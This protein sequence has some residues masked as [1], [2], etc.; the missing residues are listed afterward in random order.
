M[1]GIFD[2]GVGGLTVLHAIRQNLPSADVIYFGDTKN[3][4]YGEKSREKLSD[5]TVA[6][7]Q[8][9]QRRGAHNIVS[10]C[11]SVSASLAVSLLDA[12]DLQPGQLIEMVGPTVSVFRNADMRVALAAT[13]AT[14]SSEIYQNAFRMIGKDIQAIPVPG[15]AGAIEFGKSDEERESAIR[16]A[17]EGVDIA[18]FDVL[19]LACT[20]YPF[21]TASFKKVLGD[22]KVFDPAH[23]VAARVEKQFWPREVGEGTTTFLISAESEQ[24]RRLVHDH[25]GNTTYKVEVVQ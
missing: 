3:A 14:V 20:H 13:P 9:L 24:F 1:I 21:A 18:S 2:S 4:P 16:A 19:V 22:I 10:A 7:I 25:F 6:A 11:N 15:L 5:L 8:L 12:F 23:A 17:F